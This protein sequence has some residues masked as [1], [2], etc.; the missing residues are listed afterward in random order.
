MPSLVVLPYD[1]RWREAFVAEHARL[2]SA[3]G[4]VARRIEHN[5]STAVPGLAAKPIIDIQI[6]VRALQP[7]D[8]YGIPL[9]QLGYIH[10]PHPDDAWC[11]FFHRPRQ[12]PHTHH[13]HVVV[14][15]DD[16][17]DRTLAFRDYLCD[18]PAV[19]AEYAKLKMA[20]APRFSATEFGARQAY[21]DA[22]G[23][24]I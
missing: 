6:S 7:M 1:P 2:I 21:A 11:P 17:E 4:G 22:K 14:S 16:E 8:A 15:G 20:L 5:G 3:L 13:I 24:F 9:Q 10:L 23:E 12:W 19:A 18:H